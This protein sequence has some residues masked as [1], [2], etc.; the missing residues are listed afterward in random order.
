LAEEDPIRQLQHLLNDPSSLLERIS[1][2]Q[3]VIGSDQ[4][5]E[6]AP[7]TLADPKETDVPPYENLLRMLRDMQTQIDQ[8]VRP[9]ALQAVHEETERLRKLAD[10]EQVAQEECLAGFDRSLAICIERITESRTLRT[11]LN[12][13]NNRLTELGVAAENFR[14]CK[15]MGSMSECLQAR[16]EELRHQGKL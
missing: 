9:L 5:A 16:I 8:R 2:I 13:I 4:P 14:D 3:S 15:S 10:K 11:K 12:A 1:R 6:P 7:T